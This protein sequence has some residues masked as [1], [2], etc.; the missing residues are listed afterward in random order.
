MV[1]WAGDGEEAKTW[2]LE[3]TLI[4]ESDLDGSCGENSLVAEKDRSEEDEKEETKEDRKRENR[5]LDVWME[6]REMSRQQNCD[7]THGQQSPNL[8]A[9]EYNHDIG[10]ELFL[11]GYPLKTRIFKIPELGMFKLKEDFQSMVSHQMIQRMLSQSIALVQMILTCSIQRNTV[12]FRKGYL[13]SIQSQHPQ[14]EPVQNHGLYDLQ[15]K[16]VQ[17]TFGQ[18]SQGYSVPAPSSDPW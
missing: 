11:L 12:P 4:R 7:S 6:F 13:D 15:G 3:N 1:R 14:T 5:D 10:E 18:T 2:G 9:A 8:P 16:S 17:T